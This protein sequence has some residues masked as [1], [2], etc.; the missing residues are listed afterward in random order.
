MKSST[1]AGNTLVDRLTEASKNPTLALNPGWKAGVKDALRVFS[2]TS[3]QI[4]SYSPVPKEASRLHTQAL[5]IADD[6]DYSVT[7]YTAGID[8]LA[9]NRV[10]NA[11]DR[12]QTMS[13]RVERARQ[14]MARLQSEYAW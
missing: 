3:S 2:D 4:R 8:G 14:E 6:L 5:E 11:N 13:G 12:M 1:S 9:I 10:M 7:E